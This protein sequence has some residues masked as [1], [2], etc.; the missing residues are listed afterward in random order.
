MTLLFFLRVCET[1][2]KEK[3]IGR[4]M[5]ARINILSADETAIKTIEDHFQL[6]RFIATVLV[7]RGVDTIE[8][9]TSF[10]NASIDKD[11]TILMKSKE[12]KQLFLSLNR[13]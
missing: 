10:L 7:A 11:C 8:K 4:H 13:R 6:P 2:L 9:A 5:S 1:I 12:W 3:E